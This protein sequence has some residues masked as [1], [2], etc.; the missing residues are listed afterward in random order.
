MNTAIQIKKPL[1]QKNRNKIKSSLPKSTIIQIINN[2]VLGHKRS[3]PPHR[4]ACLLTV[5]NCSLPTIHFN[6]M[7]TSLA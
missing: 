7:L 6:I 1:N 2:L 3:T 4:N 5:D